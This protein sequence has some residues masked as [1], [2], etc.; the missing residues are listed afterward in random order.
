LR[1]I[2]LCEGYGFLAENAEFA[3][4]LGDNGISFVGPD[5]NVIGTMGDK[6]AARELANK[7]NVPTV[8]GSD[9]PIKTVDQLNHQ[10]CHG[11]RWTGYACRQFSRRIG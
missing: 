5:W 6:T 1:V 4:K 2:G 10:G 7:A 9:G 8:P 11:W 3:R